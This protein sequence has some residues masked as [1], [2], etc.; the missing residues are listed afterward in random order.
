[1]TSSFQQVPVR[2]ICLPRQCHAARL[3]KA[4][5]GSEKRVSLTVLAAKLVEEGALIEGKV[6]TTTGD[7][8]VQA[9]VKTATRLAGVGLGST[10]WYRVAFEADG[11]RHFMLCPFSSRPEEGTPATVLF[12]PGLKYAFGFDPDGHAFVGKV[13]RVG[14]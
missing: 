14:G 10:R 7:R 2:F 3:K 13:H 4:L 12:R 6:A 1:M 11:T 8:A 9:A 5:R